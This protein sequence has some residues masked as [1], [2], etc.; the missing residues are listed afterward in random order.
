[1]SE[2][3]P[4]RLLKKCT[5]LCLVMDIIIALVCLVIMLVTMELSSTV[6]ATLA[7]MW[8]VELFLSF[9]IKDREAK[10][11]KMAV[12]VEEEPEEEMSEDAPFGQSV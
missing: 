10:N 12:I 7:G 11:E 1:M 6:V 8:S 9:L 3:K 4:V 5:V 2:K